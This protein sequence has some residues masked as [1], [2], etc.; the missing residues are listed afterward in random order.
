MRIL[1]FGD[2]I[3]Y[4]SWDAGGGWV[5][6]IKRDAHLQTIQSEGMN[7]QQVINLGISGNTSTGILKRLRNEIEARHSAN[8]PFMFII[9]C[10]TNDQRMEDGI[11]ETPLDQFEENVKKII[12]IA[13]QYTDNILFIGLPPLA[14]PSVTLRTSEYSDERIK[15]Y[16]EK[17]QSIV[18][19]SG[20]PFLPIRQIF[21]KTG[22]KGLYCYDDAHP[23]DK[24]H[25]LIADTVGH[26]L[27]KKII[28]TDYST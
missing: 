22:I 20:L 18:E 15:V 16:D 25:E 13:K 9:T 28:T 6:R 3:A 26:Y 10:G 11:V 19:S 27:K 8:W 7:K 23:N 2:S 1:V 12:A 24:G 4:G 14:K 21:E 17:L 5:E